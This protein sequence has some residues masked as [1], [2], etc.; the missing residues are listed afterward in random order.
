MNIQGCIIVH[1][2][3]HQVLFIHWYFHHLNPETFCHGNLGPHWLKDP[4]DENAPIMAYL[5]CVELSFAD[6]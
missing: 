1:I 3:Y 4:D 2:L 6:D 5:D